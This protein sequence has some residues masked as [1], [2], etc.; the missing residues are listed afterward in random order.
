MSRFLLSSGSHAGTTVTRDEGERDIVW[1]EGGPSMLRCSCANSY[2][3]SGRGRTR[4]L[5]EPSP[6]RARFRRRVARDHVAVLNLKQAA[7]YLGVSFWSVRDWCLAGYLPTVELPALR[8]REGERQKDTLRRKLIDRADLDAFIEQQ[9]GG[10]ASDI[11]SAA[12]Q[13]PATTTGRCRARVPG[14]CPSEGKR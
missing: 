1:C 13:I 6:T 3:P 7:A 10:S 4:C 8:P 11:Q 2:R 9:K 14:A 5:N 12:R